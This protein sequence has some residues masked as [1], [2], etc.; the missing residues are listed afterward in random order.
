MSAPS[1][2]GRRPGGPDTR[3]QILE[4]AR[5]AFADA[6]FNGATIRA[7]ARRAHVDPALV[8]HYFG[9]KEA[10][11]NE[12]IDLPVDITQLAA[13]VLGPGLAGAGERLARIF[14]GIWETGPAHRQ[15]RAVLRAAVS[16]EEAARRMRTV[17]E[18][19][20]LAMAAASAGPGSRIRFE[21]AASHLVGLAFARYIIGVEPLA[22]VDRERLAAAV[23]PVI[24]H[25]LDAPLPGLQES[26]Q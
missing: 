13:E 16:H 3:G 25:Y 20:I 17:I 9:S 11:F 22:S 1:A 4:A 12:A 19:D 6:G 2:P 14:L 10:L 15:L 7:I 26:L 23:G 24:Q 8:L 18:G 5:E 21:L